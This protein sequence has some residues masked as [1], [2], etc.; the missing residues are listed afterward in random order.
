MIANTR[1]MSLAS[2][3]MALASSLL[4]QFNGQYWIG[5]CS[6]AT[7]VI[8]FLKQR[9]LEPDRDVFQQALH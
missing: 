2:F 7:C 5:G 6:Q 3:Y 4:D 1:W 9:S 8:I